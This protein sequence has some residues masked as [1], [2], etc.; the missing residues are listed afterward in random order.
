MPITINPIKNSKIKNQ[1]G[2]IKQVHIVHESGKFSRHNLDIMAMKFKKNIM[3]DM[4][5]NYKIQMSIH[6]KNTGWRSSKMSGLTDENIYFEYENYDFLEL[7]EDDNLINK[8]EIKEVVIYIHP[9]GKPKKAMGCQDKFNDCV[10]NA[11]QS[12]GIDVY[13]KT[14][15]KKKLGLNRCDKIPISK[16][17]DLENLERFKNYKFN[18]I[19]NTSEESYVSDKRAL[20]EVNLINNNG[21]CIPS[22]EYNTYNF[23]NP[24]EKRKFKVFKREKDNIHLYSIGK[25]GEEQTKTI[26]VNSFY[27]RRYKDN[28]TY[29]PCR[30][31]ETLKEQYESFE[32]LRKKMFKLNVDISGMGEIKM[33][34]LHYWFKFIRH[35][36]FDDVPLIEQ[37]WIKEAYYQ[38]LKYVEKDYKGKGYNYDINSYYPHLLK[39]PKNYPVKKGEFKT[40]TQEEFDEM[41]MVEYGIYK[42]IITDKHKLFQNNPNNKYTHI[43]LTTARKLGLKVK[44]ICDGQANCLLY[45]RDK[46]AT[47][48]Q[49]F[50]AF[51]NNLYELRK[52]CKDDKG[53]EKQVKDIINILSG[54]LAQKMKVKKVISEQT[55]LSNVEIISHNPGKDDTEEITYIDNTQQIYKFPFCRINPFLVGYARGNLYDIL[56]DNVD[57]IKHINTDGWISTEKIEYGDLMGSELGQIKSKYSDNIH[58]VHINK[59]IDLNNNKKF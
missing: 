52:D 11:L 13:T 29:I 54:L 18:V 31:K 55:T 43:D 10:Y 51:V 16:F 25:D 46:R 53:T 14:N 57:T 23:P 6:D 37:Q 39:G 47:G 44:L 22:K 4:G 21:H 28:I 41:E 12:M 20:F 7:D 2:Q 42:A 40:M 5:K 35:I 59:V 27:Y 34:A 24:P 9:T 17:K 48:K 58:M 1:Y 38:P 49:I 26:K 33:I 45:S 56:K 32:K 3:E 15:L 19:G 30:P 8:M 50:G 36:K